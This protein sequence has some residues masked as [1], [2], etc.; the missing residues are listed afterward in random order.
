[1]LRTI[2]LPLLMTI[3]LLACDRSPD[4][5]TAPAQS[6]VSAETPALQY[7]T[8]KK[9]AEAESEGETV[10]REGGKL[11]MD[12]HR[13]IIPPKAVPSETRFYG[14]IITGKYVVV[15]L[16][17]YRVSD[18][19]RVT[20]FAVPLELR[21]SYE[22]AENADPD[23]LVVVWLKEKKIGGQAE[24]MPGRADAQGRFVRAQLTHFSSYA[25]AMN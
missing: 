23:R 11:E 4:F 10:G 2:C 17:A 24:V 21:L 14:R 13:L 15:E 9:E 5:A 1:M 22:D 6:S 8:L 12:H 16:E 18:G 19:A 25:M 20:S 7:V 3:T